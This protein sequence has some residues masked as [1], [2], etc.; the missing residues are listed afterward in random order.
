LKRNKAL[1]A[2]DEFQATMKPVYLRPVQGSQQVYNLH[3]SP[4]ALR[5]IPENGEFLHIT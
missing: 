1:E 4:W 3:F 2:F 5:E